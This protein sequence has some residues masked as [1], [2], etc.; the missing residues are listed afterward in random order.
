M[1]DEINE[2]S[3]LACEGSTAAL[4][5]QV[6]DQV[7]PIAG[8]RRVEY[9]PVRSSSARWWAEAL[10]LLDDVGPVAAPPTAVGSWSR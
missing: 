3:P 7:P 8:E 6:L 5:T 2:V 9:A 4:T 1:S 10:I